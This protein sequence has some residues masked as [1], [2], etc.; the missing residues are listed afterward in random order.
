MSLPPLTF[1]RRLPC[2]GGQ[3]FIQ[4]LHAWEREL[5]LP[6]QHLLDFIALLPK[7]KSNDRAIWLVSWLVRLWCAL[8]GT[9]RGNS[10]MPAVGLRAFGDEA[11][12]AFGKMPRFQ[13]R[14]QTK[15]AKKRE[16]TPTTVGHGA[17]AGAAQRQ[18]ACGAGSHK[19]AVSVASVLQAHGLQ[20]G[21]AA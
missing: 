21:S 20:E 2:A 10:P 12:R 7:P 19:S 13:M 11:V 3:G 16:P 15:E 4:L 8:R 18:R 5:A 17:D 6:W 1:A 9:V 14:P